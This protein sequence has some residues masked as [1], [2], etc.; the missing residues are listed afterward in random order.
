MPR[1]K[2]QPKPKASGRNIG[3]HERNTVA[4]KL[5]VLRP[6]ADEL[7]DR[8]ERSGMTASAVVSALVMATSTD[9][10]SKADGER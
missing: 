4:I 2:P 6:V 8:A 10:G 1:R 7:R 3:E 5:R 9:D